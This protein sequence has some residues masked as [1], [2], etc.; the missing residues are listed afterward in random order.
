MKKNLLSFLGWVG[1]LDCVMVPLLF[2]SAIQQ[3][4]FLL[5]GLYFMEIAGLGL[6][7]LASV[8]REQTESWIGWLY[9]PW[10]AAGV[11]LAFNILGMWTIG[12]YLVPATIAFIWI[13]SSFANR[14]GKNLWLGLGIFVISAAAQAGL[15]LMLV[16]IV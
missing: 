13:G 15:M 9:I 11:L 14:T 3:P 12:F 8:I 16:K 2:T 5:P 10:I 7:G 6:L 4:F 1:A